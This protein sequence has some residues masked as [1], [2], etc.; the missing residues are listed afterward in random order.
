MSLDQSHFIGDQPSFLNVG[1]GKD[2]TIREMAK[3]IAKIVGFT[4]E[5]IYNSDQPDGTPRKLLDTERIKNLGW[6]PRFG[7]VDGLG[8]CLPI[9]QAG[10]QY[11]A[12]I[13]GC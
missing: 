10:D 4:G 2:M 7:L 5:T 12:L 8:G 1:S 11:L 9:L 13:S 6:Q 3:L